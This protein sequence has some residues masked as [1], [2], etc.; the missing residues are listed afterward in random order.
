MY[1]G[2]KSIACIRESALLCYYI[3]HHRKRK[4]EKYI[5]SYQKVVKK[6]IS[7]QKNKTKQKTKNNEQNMVILTSWASIKKPLNKG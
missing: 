1:R 6:A 7:L 4:K 3:K 2:K 5:K